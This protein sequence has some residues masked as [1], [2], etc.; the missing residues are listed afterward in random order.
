MTRRSRTDVVGISCGLGNQLFQYSWA[1]WL[2]ASGRAVVLDL[3]VLNKG[4]R[5]FGLSAIDPA[6]DF[7][8]T[9]L[10]RWVPSPSN[11][12]PTVGKGVRIAVGPRRVVNEDRALT[13]MEHDR[14]RPAWWDGYWQNRTMVLDVI[15]QLRRRIVPREP[16]DDRIGLHVRRDDFVEIGRDLAPDYYRRAVAELCAN[17]PHLVGIDIYSDDTAW[18]EMH[19]SDLA[20]Q[21]TVQT[22]GAAH[23][24]LLDLASHRHLVL[25]LGTFSW[26]ASHLVERPAGVVVAPLDPA[27]QAYVPLDDPGWLLVPTV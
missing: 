8:T 3:S 24:D 12:A 1:L 11:R 9:G 19:L 7:E 5:S 18:C 27:P 4:V 22:G 13:P 14:S 21:A 17:H 25:S 23:D 2:R 16:I 26:W 15:D 20:L 6:F 10:P